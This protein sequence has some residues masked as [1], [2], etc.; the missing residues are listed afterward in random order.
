MKTT[1]KKI[2]N[3]LDDELMNIEVSS[4]E[5]ANI[6]IERIKGE[7]F[8]RIHNNDNINENNTSK[9]KISKKLIAILI[10]ATMVVGTTVG[11]FATGSIQQ[12]FGNYFKGS[13]EL[14]DF[15]LYNGGDVEVQTDDDNLDVTLLG[16]MSDGNIAYSAIEVTHKD[17]SPIVEEG[18]YLRSGY[19]CFAENTFEYSYNGQTNKNDVAIERCCSQLSDDRKTLTIYTDYIRGTQYDYNMNDYRVTYNNKSLGTYTLDKVLYS[20]E[21]PETQGDDGLTDEQREIENR[22]YELTLERVLRENGLTDEDCITIEQDGKSVFG[23]GEFG[24]I[25]MNFTISFSFNRN[26]DKLIE[27]DI[28]SKTTPNVVKDYARNTK[29]VVTPLGVSLK[30][31][32]NNSAVESLDDFVGKCFEIPG[33]D[34]SSKVIMDNGTVYY[35]LIN[36]GGDRRVDDNE[37]YHET[38]ELQYSTTEDMAR[39]LASNRIIID[40]D[41]IQ[42]VIINGDTIYEK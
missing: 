34:G 17:G 36:E 8:M 30:G 6:D 40:I 41:K 22:Q 15:G 20:E 14:N 2:F 16:V 24:K 29:A 18:I 31:E 9:K 11:A 4:P 32:C 27:R 42:T 13:G 5:A 33:F 28:D 23:K 12:I 10:A 3:E 26:I 37:V 39:N 1:F 21:L 38:I 35:I 19:S 7:V 25:D